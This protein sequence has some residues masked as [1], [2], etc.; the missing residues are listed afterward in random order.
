MNY[1]SRQ[2]QG[3]GVFVALLLLVVVLA[4]AG[5]WLWQDYQRFRTT[6]LHIS[7]EG[8]NYQVRP[9]TSLTAV[10]NDLKSRGI[11]RQPLYLRALAKELGVSMGQLALAWVIS[12]PGTCAIAGARNGEQAAANA[13]AA[14]VALAQDDIARLDEIGRLVTDYLD[15]SP[16]MWSF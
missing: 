15:D 6:T 5:Y 9:G 7:G 13:R 12:H 2:H 8:F 1:T 10:A 3:G 11:L 16:V 4:A 14:D